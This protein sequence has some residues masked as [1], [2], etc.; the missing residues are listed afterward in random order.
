MK[1]LYLISIIEK[2]YLNGLTERVKISIKDKTATIK[3]V[4]TQKNVVGVIEA[5][6]I[7]LDDCELGIYDTTQLLKLLSITDSFLT[8]NLIN[9]GKIANKLLI[10]DKEYNLEY[11]LADI[12]LVP[13]TPTVDEPEYELEA[14]IDIEFINKFIKAKK[15]LD[16]EI[17][18]IDNGYDTDNNPVINFLLG[19]TDNY[20]NK[21]NFSIK[22]TKSG[23]PI[24]PVKFPI[25]EFREILDSNKDI[26]SGKLYINEQGLL[27]VEFIGKEGEKST[28][29]V[30]GKD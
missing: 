27:K 24:V 13:I 12:M 29:L 6:N 2:Y 10:A 19:G 5:P 20:T 17:F 16:T 4:A 1:K 9:Q 3:F 15:A 25:N 8:L 22:A 21:I 28:Y 23:L 14:N 30:V 26:N 18:I 7:A 11:S